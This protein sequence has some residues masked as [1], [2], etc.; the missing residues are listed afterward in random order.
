[1]KHV[2]FLSAACMLKDNPEARKDY[3]EYDL[4]I[5]AL[6]PAC[7]EAGIELVTRIW[8]D[9]DFDASHYDAAVIGTCWDY[10]QKPEAFEAALETIAGQTR[11]LNPFEI[12]RWNQRKTYLKDLAARGAP[13]IPTLWRDRAD[14][15]TID[16]AFEALGSDDIVVKPVLGG[17]AWRQA[18]IR[19]GEALPSPENLPIAECMIQPFL[20]AVSQ[21]GEY[22]FLF[23]GREFSHCARKLP[24]AGDYRVQS[25]YG[26]REEIHH[27]TDEELALA[28]S[29][30]ACVEGDLLYARID[31]LRGL[32]GQLAL[33]ELE[34]IEPYLYPQQGPD[35]GAAFARALKALI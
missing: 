33:I 24:A 19:R 21:E 6:A 13:M 2:A 7:R 12:F 23:F 27:P 8:D 20:P 4:E 35:M 1:M 3:W 16:A 30:L 10:M 9:P 31:M 5:S 32:D 25:E 34:L 26:G 22:A 11:L 18:R 28:N 17:G 14:A 15:A 29:V